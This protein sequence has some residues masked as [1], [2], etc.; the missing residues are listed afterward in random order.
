MHLTISSL[1]SI[2]DISVVEIYCFLAQI[3]LMEH[4]VWDTYKAYW[5]INKLHCTCICSEIM[6]YDCFVHVMEVLHFGSTWHSPDRV[7]Q[8]MRRGKSEIFDYVSKNMYYTL[9]HQKK[10]KYIY[11]AVHDLWIQG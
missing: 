10:K 3:I 7:N 1:A 4:D 9:Y 2:V 8:I 5:S 6:K 11:S